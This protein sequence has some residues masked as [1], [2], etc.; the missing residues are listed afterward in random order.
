MWFIRNSFMEV[1]GKTTM[2]RDYVS[3][4]QHISD[5]LPTMTTQQQQAARYLLEH[6]HDVGLRSMRA[7][8]AQAQVK[9]MAKVTITTWSER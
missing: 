5:S 3:L 4:L 6:P 1:K 8:A 9:S 2:S 7:I